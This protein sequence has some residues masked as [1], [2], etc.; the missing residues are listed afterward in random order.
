MYLYKVSDI[1][2]LC[3]IDLYWSYLVV[4]SQYNVAVT[5]CLLMGYLT[6]CLCTHLKIFG[7]I[8]NARISHYVK[9]QALE[10]M[11]GCRE[12]SPCVRAV[13]VKL[14]VLKIVN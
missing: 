7:G 9:S 2:R 13:V 4:L 12:L 3:I 5:S 11:C 14:E 1:K 8:E 6:L 10:F